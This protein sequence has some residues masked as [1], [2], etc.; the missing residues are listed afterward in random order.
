MTRNKRK[1]LTSILVGL[2]A[3]S[4]VGCGTEQP[5]EDSS[6]PVE[7]AKPITLNG[8]GATFPHPLYTAM[9]DEYK[10]QNPNVTVNY[11]AVGSGA[12]IKQISEQTVD[13]GGTDGPMK[14]EQLAEAKGG[15]ILHVPTALG[16]VAVVYNVPGVSDLRLAPDVLTDIFLGKITKWNDP[17]IAADNPGVNLPDMPITVAHRSD[18][19]GTTFIFVDYLSAVSSEWEASVG[20]GTSVNWPTG[21]G[22]K[23]NAGVA[24]VVQQTPGTIGYVEL[25]YAKQNNIAYAELK[26]KDGNWVKPSL[27]GASAAAAEAQIPDDMRVSIVNAPG[28]DSYPISGFT[29]LLIYKNQTDKEKGTA[30]VNLANWMIHDGQ[31][32]NEGLD[33]ARLPENLVDRVETNLKTVNYQGESLLK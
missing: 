30:V 2:L 25:A 24:G 19:S 9:F 3:I 14:D 4:L 22:G 31:E 8:A 7:E 12:G 26:N 29:W 10:K 11:Q 20:K 6:A 15:E 23:G 5:V 1:V 17:R 27:E 28:A 13:F 18:G 33:Y 16:A 32:L 21:I